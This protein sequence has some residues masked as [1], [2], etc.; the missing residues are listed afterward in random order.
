MN[1]DKEIQRLSDIWYRY[2]SLDHHKDRD[3]HFTINKTWSYGNEAEYRAEHSGYVAQDW[4]GEKR[5]TYAE[6]A[7]DLIFLLRRE[8]QEHITYA[9]RNSKLPI[10]EYWGEWDV[11]NNKKQLEI[12][13]EWKNG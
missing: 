6:S 7:W 2:V 12:L 9:E 3:C 11:E 1:L 13:G 5:E 10:Q 4:Y 8:I